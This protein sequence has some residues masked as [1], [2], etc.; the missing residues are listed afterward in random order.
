M[1]NV[2]SFRISNPEGFLR[3]KQS[4]LGNRGESEGNDSF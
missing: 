3:L 2:N 1:V 4:G